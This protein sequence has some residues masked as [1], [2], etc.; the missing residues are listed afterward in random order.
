MLPSRTPVR[1]GFTLI[2]LLVVIAI[3]AIL[4]SL[5]LPA[6]QSVREA[7]RRTECSNHLHQLVIAVHNY[8]GSHKVSPPSGCVAGTSV[9]QPWSGQAFIL[10]YL[11]GG[12]VYARIDFSFG[13]HHQTNKD[14]FPPSGIAAERIPVLLCPSEPN[15]RARVDS[16]T[17]IHYPLNYVLNLGQYKIFDPTDGSDGGG[18]FAPNGKLGPRSYTDGMSNILGLSEVKAMV[19][20]FHDATGVP[21]PPSGPLAVS[22]GYTAGGAFSPSNGHSEWVCGRAIHNGFTTTFGPNTRVPHVQGGDEFDINVSSRREGASATE[23]TYAIITSRS[24]HPGLV[25][26]AMMDGR[27]RSFSENLSLQVWQA[28]GTRDGGEPVGA[29]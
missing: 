11:E 12:N 4:V 20:R 6:V 16:P 21:T 28:L 9:S 17:S 25:Q 22:A 14:A 5:L 24:W 8:E 15:D 23:V 26:S 19:P 1:R 29:N 18:A 3:I 13:Y 2:E 10:P 7:A 27:V